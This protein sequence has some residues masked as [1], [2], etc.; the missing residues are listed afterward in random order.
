MTLLFMM[1]NITPKPEAEIDFRLLRRREKAEVIRWFDRFADPVYGFIFYRVDRDKDL[2]GE[3][4]QET[5]AI[6]LEKI[7]RFDPSR[8]EMFPWLTHIA[9]N[10]IRKALRHQRRGKALPNFWETIDRRLSKAVADSSSSVVLEEQ[11]ER[12]ETAELVRMALS[13][14][15]FRYQTALRRRYFEELSLHEMAALEGSSEGATKVLLHRARQ[16]FRTAFET[17]SASFAENESGGRTI[18]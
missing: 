16:A 15:P 4:A 5:F 1:R 9:R 8:G 3:V 13:N 17:I 11:L 14:L 10:C 18:P 7:D 2:A 6:A 12:K